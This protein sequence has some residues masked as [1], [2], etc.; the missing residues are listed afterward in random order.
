M[1]YKLLNLRFNEHL[2]C[3]DPSDMVEVRRNQKG[4][5]LPASVVVMTAG[6]AV[7]SGAWDTSNGT[8]SASV[9]V[10]DDQAYETAKG[11]PLVPGQVFLI[12]GSPWVVCE[13]LDKDIPY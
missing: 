5:L 4:S 8:M 10:V 9:R 13:E 6:E 11:V 2:V 7:D 1:S 12:D 3:V